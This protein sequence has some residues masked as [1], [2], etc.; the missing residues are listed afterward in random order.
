MTSCIRYQLTLVGTVRGDV[1]HNTFYGAIITVVGW[2]GM[3]EVGHITYLLS[4]NYCGWLAR[5]WTRS[6]PI[7]YLTEPTILWLAGT[8][9]GEI[10][11]IT[12]HGTG[13]TVLLWLGGTV[14]DEGGPIAY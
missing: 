4:Q 1:A 11:S 12:L 13:I 14:V 8:V 6:G 9:N 7:A 3:G 5:L 2:H 10:G